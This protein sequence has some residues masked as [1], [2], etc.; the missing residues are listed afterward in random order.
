MAHSLLT[1]DVLLEFGACCELLHV[2]Q[3][4]SEA[5]WVAGLQLCHALLC[6]CQR[7]HVLG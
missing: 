1:Q 7:H 6:G 3:K 5:P 4:C 2:T